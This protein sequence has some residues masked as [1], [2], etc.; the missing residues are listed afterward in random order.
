MNWLKNQISVVDF[1]MLLQ[2]IFDGI[3]FQL[4]FLPPCPSNL[5]LLEQTVLSENIILKLV[6]FLMSF[7]IP[8]EIS[9][10]YLMWLFL[11]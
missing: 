4:C 3:Y 2:V 8:L 9:H 11:L 5:R 1:E 6:E 7:P 10:E